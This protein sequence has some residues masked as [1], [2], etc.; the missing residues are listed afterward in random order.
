M[1]FAI[2]LNGIIFSWHE[3]KLAINER[4]HRLSLEQAAQAYFDPFARFV[5]A[6]RHGE[7]REA[8]IGRD[9]QLNLLYVVHVQRAEDDLLIISARPAT[10]DEEQ[11]YD[12]Q[13]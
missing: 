4:K 12:D 9:F 11:Y 6:S 2:D 13:F 7:S 3:R 5:D 10:T 8:Y 1:D